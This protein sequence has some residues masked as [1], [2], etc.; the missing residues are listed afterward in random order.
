MVRT[1]YF[2][3]VLT[4][5][6]QEASERPDVLAPREREVLELVAGGLSNGESAKER[7]IEESTVKTH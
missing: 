1:T 6:T 7:V 3:D 5:L 2:T 4:S